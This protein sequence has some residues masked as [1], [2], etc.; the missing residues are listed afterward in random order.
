MKNREEM[1]ELYTTK[2]YYYSLA[3]EG[4]K[5]YTKFV[6]E[7]VYKT[8]GKLDVFRKTKDSISEEERFNFV[9]EITDEFEEEAKKL[10]DCGFRTEE[11]G[12]VFFDQ[13]MGNIEKEN[14]N[15]VKNDESNKKND[16][17]TM[18][19]SRE[20]MYELYT[21]KNYYYSLSLEGYED[22]INFV[23]EKVYKTWE[24]LDIFRKTKDSISEE[25]RFN[26]AKEIA[27]EFEDEAKKL[28]DCGFYIEEDG[29]ACF[30]PDIR[31]E[32]DNNE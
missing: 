18:P 21:T 13:C 24:K 28:L 7:K 26:F 8:W 32:N 12:H 27:D 22:Y 17:D 19:K 2:N 10:L 29:Y 15:F 30:D 20:E 3:L 6:F 5:D 14:N 25:E 9:K 23:F 1:Y 31:K 11:D 16:L 4:Y